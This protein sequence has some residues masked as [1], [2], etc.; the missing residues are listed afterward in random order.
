MRQWAELYYIFPS[1]WESQQ[2]LIMT[3]LCPFVLLL[4]FS[5]TRCLSGAL[6]VVYFTAS[7]LPSLLFLVVVTT[8]KFNQ[9]M[10]SRG[11]LQVHHWYLLSN[12]SLNQIQFFI[13]IPQLRGLYSTGNRNRK[14]DISHDVWGM[15]G[16]GGGNT[17][18]EGGTDPFPVVGW[19][20][21]AL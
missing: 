7:A 15:K 6:C 19:R 11:Q 20:S 4:N 12:I 2:H 9:R 18:Q 16:G 21:A 17:K 13:C 5:T 10:R 3:N 14:W 8:T 1:V